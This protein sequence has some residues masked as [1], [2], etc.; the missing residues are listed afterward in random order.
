MELSR[1]KR[2]TARIITAGS[3]PS[4]VPVDVPFA[5]PT[6]SII[7]TYILDRRDGLRERDC[8]RLADH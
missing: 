7:E 1:I 6:S 5:A 2:I 3:W 4:G 8:A